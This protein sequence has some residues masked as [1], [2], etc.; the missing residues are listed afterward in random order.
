MGSSDAGG[1]DL[2]TSEMSESRAEY[3]VKLTGSQ[4]THTL[5][6]LRRHARELAGNESDDMSG[7]YEDL[8]V[9]E[10]IIRRFEQARGRASSHPASGTGI[11]AA[12]GRVRDGGAK[13]AGER[14]P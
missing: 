3:S 11:D 6:A 9:V 12:A 4:L 13:G 14:E 10:E 1:R 5:V 7:D 2:P 8:L